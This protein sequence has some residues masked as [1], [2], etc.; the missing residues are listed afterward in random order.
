MEQDEFALVVDV[1]TKPGSERE[2]ESL[3][4]EVVERQTAEPTYIGTTVHRDPDDPTHF[5]L[6]EA[7]R[8]REDFE[9]VQMKRSYR[10]KYEE[11]LDRLLERPRAMTF[12]VPTWSQGR[13]PKASGLA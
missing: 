5:V 7:W 3:M 9:T 13:L 12:I 6:Y 4:L 1:K 11:S 10:R 8:D 2:Y